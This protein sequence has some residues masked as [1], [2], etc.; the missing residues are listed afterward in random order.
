MNGKPLPVRPPK[1]SLHVKINPDVKGLV[2]SHSTTRDRSQ[3]M[4]VEELV[5]LGALTFSLVT[6]EMNFAGFQS[7]IMRL[8]VPVHGPYLAN[9]PPPAP[10]ESVKKSPVSR[11]ALRVERRKQAMASP[12]FLPPPT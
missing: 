10:A 2:D 5:K 12:A 11:Q 9:N 8:G 3:A 7:A 1:V 4:A 6:G